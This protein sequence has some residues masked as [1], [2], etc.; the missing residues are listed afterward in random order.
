MSVSDDDQAKKKY[1][2]ENIDWMYGNIATADENGLFEDIDNHD[3]AKHMIK[4]LEEIRANILTPSPNFA[5]S[6]ARF[7]ELRL[8]FY[9]IVNA[10][11]Y[12]RFKYMYSGPIWIYFVAFLALVF[13]FYS[14]FVR[15]NAEICQISVPGVLLYQTHELSLPQS[16]L[17]AATW[18]LI[19]AILQG[20]Y[21][22]WQSVSDFRYRKAWLVWA[23][24]CPFLGGI[25]G[26]LV[27]FLLASGLL[28]LSSGSTNTTDINKINPFIIIAIAVYAGY[29]WQ[30]TINWLTQVAERFRS[31]SAN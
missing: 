6:E 9:K 4:R 28:I 11:R 18:G 10:K 22:N 19:G 2:T 30:Q 31:T 23:I 17:Y 29:N 13:V 27:Y 7:Y 1:W 25:F 3:K 5:N 24:S 16:A 26:A 20:L 8:D 15:C 12:W 14:Y 21:W